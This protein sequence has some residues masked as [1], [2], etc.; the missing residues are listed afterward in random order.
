MNKYTSY[1]IRKMGLPGFFSWILK[2]YANRILKKK[3]AKKPKYLYIDANCLF[4]PQCF[5][6]LEEFPHDNVSQL[7]NKM[8]KAIV[9]FLD[10]LESYVDPSTMMFIAVDGTAPLAKIIQQRKRRYK[11]ELENKNKNE[12]KMKY[13]ILSNTAWSNTSI[14]PGTEFME[15]LHVYLEHHYN[16]K[17]SKHKYIYSSYHEPGEGEHK[18]MEHIRNKTEVDDNIIIYGLDADLIFLSMSSGR[19]DIHL[20]RE[21]IE[22]KKEIKQEEKTTTTDLIYVSIKETKESY[23][24]EMQSLFS[25]EK[26]K[27]IPQFDKINFADDF[28][29]LCFLLG[30][31]FLPH[32]PSIDIHSGGLDELIRTYIYGMTIIK[33]PLISVKNKIVTVDNTFFFVICQEMGKKEEEYFTNVLPFHMEK[34][35][36]RKCHE[37]DPYKKELFL[38]ENLRDKYEKGDTLE[39]G[40][41]DKSVWK[42]RYYEYYFKTTGDQNKI[43]SKLCQNYIEGIKWITEYYFNKCADWR[44]DYVPYYAPFISD[45]AIYLKVNNIDINS[46]TFS[47]RGVVPMYAQLVSVLPPSCS[48]LLPKKFRHLITTKESEII[49]MFPSKIKVDTLYKNQLWQCVPRIPYLNI[50][51]ICD[52]IEKL[53]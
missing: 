23:N 34:N 25:E 40:V 38:M 13:G 4:H 20:V 47:D 2:K 53:K 28:V 41:G 42:Y 14:T 15:E 39:L 22:F 11:S 9:E 49:D 29:F 26:K 32:F 3:L 17:K 51:R 36:R 33:R 37:M 31:D 27:S 50:N 44:W 10:Y 43:I 30:N 21:T 1:Y 16:N 18:I 46:I 8:F 6:V 7:K 35:K 12:L 45:I 24:Y 19:N 5:K 48:H 52:A